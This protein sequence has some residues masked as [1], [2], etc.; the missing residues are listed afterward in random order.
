[1]AALAWYTMANYSQI[2]RVLLDL[3]LILK[4]VLTIKKC[5]T[6]SNGY[7]GVDRAF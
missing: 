5:T 1:M 6:K 2:K 7:F 4:K 3:L